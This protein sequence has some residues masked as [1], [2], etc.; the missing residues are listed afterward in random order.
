MSAPYS[1]G[2]SRIGHVVDQ[3]NG[4]NRIDRAAVIKPVNLTRLRG[5]QCRTDDTPMFIER[6]GHGCS[7][8]LFRRLKPLRTCRGERLVDVLDDICT[9]LDADRQPDGLGQDAGHALLFGR[10][11]AVGG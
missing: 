6:L 3:A 2:F 4:E 8:G 11:L 7:V 9:V 10:H 5:H 1:N